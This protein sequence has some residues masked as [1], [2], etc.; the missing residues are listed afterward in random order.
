ML[1]IISNSDGDTSIRAVS[2][3]EFLSELNDGDYPS[4]AFLDLIEG[5]TDPNYWPEGTLLVIKGEV[6]V[7][8]PKTVVKQ[9]SL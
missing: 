6:V 9:Y 1:F 4:V 8:K 2:E 3:E 7:P 5:S